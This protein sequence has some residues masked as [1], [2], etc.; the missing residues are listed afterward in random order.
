MKKMFTSTL[1]VTILTVTQNHLK[2]FINAIYYFTIGFHNDCL[3]VL[4]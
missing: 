4:I 2:I 3:S 1:T